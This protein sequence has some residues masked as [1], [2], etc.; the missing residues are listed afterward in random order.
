MYLRSSLGLKRFLSKKNFRLTFFMKH[1]R[2]LCVTRNFFCLT[3]RQRMVAMLLSQKFFV[4]Y[5]SSQIIHWTMR[6]LRTNGS[7]GSSNW[8]MLRGFYKPHPASLIS[9]CTSTD[10]DDFKKLQLGLLTG[11]KRSCVNDSMS[12]SVFNGGRMAAASFMEFPAWLVIGHN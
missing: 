3:C 2:Q 11:D 12:S 9:R 1:E 5:F 6:T 8:D 4:V 7:S 10:A